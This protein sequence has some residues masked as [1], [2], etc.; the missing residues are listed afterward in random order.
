MKTPRVQTEERRLNVYDRAMFRSGILGIFWQAIQDKKR[1]DR[2]TLQ[3]V[4]TKLHIGR[5]AVSR[6][7]SGDPPNWQADTMVDIANALDL[8]LIITA[9][10]R[11]TGTMYSASGSSAP[12]SAHASTSGSPSII[13]HRGGDRARTLPEATGWSLAA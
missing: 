8:D 2:F 11:I 12:E 5:S 4:A 3:D 1:R 7:F 10:S 6:W 13:E 9:R